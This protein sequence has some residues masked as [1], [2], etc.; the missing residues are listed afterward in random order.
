[1]FAALAKSL[2]GDSNDREVK[3]LTPQVQQINDAEQKFA[4]L[5]DE[6]LRAQTDKF[7]DRLAQGEQLDNLLIEAFAT[8]REAAKRT[9]G[10]RHFDVQLIGGMVLHSGRISEMKTGEGKTLISLCTTHKHPE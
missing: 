6:E 4:A 5:T 3:R 1:M 10:Q 2:F 8:V 7:K 9:L